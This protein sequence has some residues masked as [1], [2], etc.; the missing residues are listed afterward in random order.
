MKS[1]L[2][3]FRETP[4]DQ[5]PDDDHLNRPNPFTKEEMDI[6]IKEMAEEHKNDPPAKPKSTEAKR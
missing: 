3:R 4:D 5:F 2:Q 1:L 6:I